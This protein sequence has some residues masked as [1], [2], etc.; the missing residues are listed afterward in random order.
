MCI[1]FS[2]RR[3]S[4]TMP[5]GIKTTYTYDNDD[6][7]TNVETTIKMSGNAG[8]QY[9]FII[10]G[11]YVFSEWQDITEST[12]RDILKDTIAIIATMLDGDAYLVYEFKF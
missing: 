5:N 8:P 2:R 11:N 7:L 4:A 10:R 12:L 3:T 1:F 6:R 9:G